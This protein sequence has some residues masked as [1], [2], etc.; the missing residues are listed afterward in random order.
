MDDSNRFCG[1]GAEILATAV[2]EM[3]LDAPPVR[4]TRPDGAVVGCHPEL[5]MALQPTRE[6]LTTAIRAVMKGGW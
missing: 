1:L 2:E 5:D 3:R 4:V 6:Q